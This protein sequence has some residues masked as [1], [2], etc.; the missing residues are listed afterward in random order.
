MAV[1]QATES[2]TKTN[3]EKT[4]TSQSSAPKAMDIHPLGTAPTVA[5]GRTVVIGNKPMAGDPMLSANKSQQTSG[6][7][8]AENSSGDTVTAPVI[9][10]HVKT[11]SPLE[12]NDT[13][14]PLEQENDAVA[15]S[16]EVTTAKKVKQPDDS[17]A[18]E[19]I[20]SGADASDGSETVSDSKEDK[21]DKAVS[22]PSLNEKPTDPA[23]VE[24]AVSNESDENVSPAAEEESALQEKTAEQMREEQIETLIQ[25]KTYAVPI[26]KTGRRRHNAVLALLLAVILAVIALNFLLDFGVITIPGAPSTD[27]F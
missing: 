23:P 15:K 2:A 21:A 25:K 19:S 11:I 1:K 22:A 8:P 4:A 6:T 26:D 24:E 5:A 7:K 13:E 16:V 3:A 27:L 12:N 10:H 18:E 20:Q 14:E 9:S 17:G